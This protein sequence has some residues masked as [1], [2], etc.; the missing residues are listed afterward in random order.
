MEF[1]NLIPDLLYKHNCVILPD[2]GGFIANFKASEHKT[3]RFLISP[4]RK[5]IAFNQS[6]K[7]NDG[8]LI[9]ELA[10]SKKIPYSKAEA[11]VQSYIEFIKTRLEKYKN[12]EFKNVGTFYLNNEENLLF[13]PYQGLNFLEKSFG[14]PDVKVKPL[15]NHVTDTSKVSTGP[16]VVRL[17]KKK[18]SGSNRSFPR[19][20]AAVI[21]VLMV[22]GF[23]TM[24]LNENRSLERIAGLDLN[25]PSDQISDTDDIATASIFPVQTDSDS[26][27][28]S[29]DLHPEEEIEAEE[30]PVEE[31]EEVN[32]DVE[33]EEA[34]IQEAQVEPE[35]EE[36]EIE[37]PVESSPSASVE[38][39]IRY[40]RTM[41]RRNYFHVMIG[42]FE[43]EA[44]A[45]RWQRRYK[46]KQYSAD[47]ID[48]YKEGKYLISLEFFTQEAHAIAF[49][50]EVR[51]SE[52]RR[53]WIVELESK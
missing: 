39:I 19:V 4:A 14:L 16:K 52:R 38:S 7:E 32:P 33:Q 21:I 34:E 43:S 50:R 30:N 31:I 12:F 2:F 8:L 37:T 13:V 1:T 25:K 44:E 41:S 53:T 26:E 42:E 5:I 17:D 28:D 18:S 45:V 3:E 36:A 47:I 35:I 29:D 46:N 22:A 10:K 9:S 40:R 23:S 15:F 20:A 49:Q 27:S 11:E 51:V 24:Y 48:D 6:L